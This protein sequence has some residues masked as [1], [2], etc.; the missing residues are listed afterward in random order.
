MCKKVNFLIC[1]VLVLGLLGSAFGQRVVWDDGGADHLWKTPE[2]WD[3]DK[4]PTDTN[5]VG[6]VLQEPS[7][8]IIDATHTGLYVA[9]ANN[10][11]VGYNLSGDLRMTGGFLTV[12]GQTQVGYQSLGRFYMEDGT[13]TMTAT[14]ERFTLGPSSG[15]GILDV[16]GGTL[17]IG[18]NI[19]VGD[20]YK[21]GGAINMQGGTILAGGVVD[22]G[23]NSATGT[24]NMEGGTVDVNEDLWVG[25]DGGSTGDVNIVD[26]SIIVGDDLDIGKNGGSGVLTIAGGSFTVSD[27]AKVGNNTYGELHI[28]GGSVTIGG[29]QIA[30]RPGADGSFM[31]MSGGSLTTTKDGKPLKVGGEGK[32]LQGYTS[33]PF[34]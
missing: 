1:F 29:L 21:S 18:G 27:A 26:G 6:I 22:V 16:Q 28:S 24:I 34:N 14:D 31:T 3:T 9:E 17:D 4:V 30:Y 19:R 12:G 32:K 13:F 23:R 2:N 11:G 20:G 15:D 7:G 10:L 8:C 33:Q 25:R 5:D